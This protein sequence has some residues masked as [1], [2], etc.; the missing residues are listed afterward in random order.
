[1]DV[2]KDWKLK[3]RYGKL[4]TPY[5]HYTLIAPVII[6]EFIEDFEAKPGHAYLGMKIWASDYDEAVEIIENIGIQTGY[7]I[8]GKIEIYDTPPEQP[9]ADHPN[10]YGINFSY[11]EAE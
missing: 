1:M 8:N 11:Y 3:L 10:A 5:K 6:N 2:D 7:Q 4:K 9:P